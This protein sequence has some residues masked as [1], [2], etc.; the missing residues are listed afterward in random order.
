MAQDNELI[1]MNY[2]YESFKGLDNGQRM[3]IIDWVIARFGLTEEDKFKAPVSDTVI[4]PLAETPSLS[5]SPAPAAVS[6]PEAGAPSSATEITR[7]EIKDYD[8]VIDLFSD[9]NAKKVSQKIVL[10]TAFLQERLNFAEVSSYDVNSRLKRIKQGVANVTSS[11]NG[12]LKKSPPLLEVSDPKGDANSR[13]RKFR[14]TE[15]GL[16]YARSM[17]NK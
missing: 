16:D 4:T 15:Q 14:L 17:L 7:R 11:I 13:R 3:R 9:A 10:M 12:V 1:A 8:K 5:S 6:V 2:V